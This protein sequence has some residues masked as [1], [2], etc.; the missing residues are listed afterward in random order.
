MQQRPREKGDIL[1]IPGSITKPPA[2]DRATSFYTTN[3]DH[4]DYSTT[5]TNAIDSVDSFSLSKNRSVL[6]TTTLDSPGEQPTTNVVY[7]DQTL[8]T[9]DNWITI[10]LS[11]VSIV[12]LIVFAVLYILA[13]VILIKIACLQF[14]IFVCLR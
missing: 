6:N 5:T 2:Y 12:A 14:L 7:Y 9:A 4:P 10:T 11:A 13:K 8:L 3:I 1:V